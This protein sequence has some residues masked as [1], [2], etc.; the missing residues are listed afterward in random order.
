MSFDV[1]ARTNGDYEVS[2][3]ANLA[4]HRGDDAVSLIYK[5]R[6]APDFRPRHG[7]FRQT[8]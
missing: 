3:T 4:P 5:G 6:I 7:S 8:R 2:V 1:T